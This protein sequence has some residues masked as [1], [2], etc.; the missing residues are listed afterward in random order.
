MHFADDELRA[1]ER[2]MRQAAAE[3]RDI[4]G[5]MKAA[6]GGVRLAEHFADQAQKA[7]AIADK[8]TAEIG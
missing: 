1:I 2:A 5:D 7:D 8:I 3:Y 4:R 6:A